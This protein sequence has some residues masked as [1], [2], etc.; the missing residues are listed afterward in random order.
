MSDS[1]LTAAHAVSFARNAAPADYFALLKP[2]VMS[3]VVFTS[4][5]GMVLA[6]GELHPVLVFAA[7][8][9]ESVDW[10]GNKIPPFGA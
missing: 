3:L 5:V 1:I 9:W 10:C 4:A 7:L 2:R 6:P 8:F